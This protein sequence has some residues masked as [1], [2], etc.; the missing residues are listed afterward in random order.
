MRQGCPAARGPD[1]FPSSALR[2]CRRAPSRPRGLDSSPPAACGVG[3][4]AAQ[5]KSSRLL[6]ISFTRE[7]HTW[8]PTTNHAETFIRRSPSKIVAQ[9]EDGIRPWLKPWNAEHAA[10]RITRPLRHN[11][12]PYHG[13]NILMLWA[14]AEEQ[15]FV[16]PYWLTFKQAQSL[17]GHVRKGEK[18]SPVVYASTFEKTDQDANGDEVERKIP[19]LKQY[20]VF[21]R[22]S[23]AKACQLTITR[24]S[25]RPMKVSNGSKQPTNSFERP[26]PRFVKAEPKPITRSELIIFRCP[27]LNAFAMPN[28]TR[29]PSPMSYVTG[30]GTLLA[31]IEI[32]ATRNGA[33]RAMPWKNWSRNLD[34]RFSVLIFRSRR[35]S[36]PTTPPIW[37]AG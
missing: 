9:L 26:K 16:S 27:S 2:L 20:T 29:A 32:W 10:G 18:G 33:T 28:L 1:A 12:E 8:P 13:I 23:G 35:K 5:K 31:W 21:R 17:G 7:I 24:C 3:V 22:G 25:S 14:S 6:T 11:G 36:C 4:A 19:F 37:P 15:G 30:R 34:R